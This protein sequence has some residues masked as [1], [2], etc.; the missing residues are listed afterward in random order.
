MSPAFCPEIGK[1]LADRG[2]RLIFVER[3]ADV[4]DQGPPAMWR[5]TL[6]TGSAG[7]NIPGPSCPQDGGVKQ[8]LA[9]GES[10]FGCAGCQPQDLLKRKA[11]DP[12]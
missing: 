10:F 8:E 12:E 7:D 6:T 3:A 2:F 11:S 4:G 1:S 9:N 5:R